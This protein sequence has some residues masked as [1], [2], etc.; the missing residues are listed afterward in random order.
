MHSFE[1][2]SKKRQELIDIS[3]SIAELTREN[4]K[5]KKSCVIFMSFTP[6]L[7]SFRHPWI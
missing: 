6:F 3:A 7:N 5:G 4:G 2:K 1:V